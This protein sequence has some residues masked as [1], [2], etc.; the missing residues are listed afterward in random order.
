MYD[1]EMYVMKPTVFTFEIF[2]GVFYDVSRIV[3]T[4][5]SIV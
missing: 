3:F 4:Q 1:N 5:Y 2:H